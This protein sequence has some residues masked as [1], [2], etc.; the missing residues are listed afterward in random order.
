[1]A[2]NAEDKQ[3]IKAERKAILEFEKK[4]VKKED[5]LLNL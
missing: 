5:M 1:L 3:A 2:K 4:K